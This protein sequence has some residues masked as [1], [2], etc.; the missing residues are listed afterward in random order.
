MRARSATPI[1]L[2]LTK[3][4]VWEEGRIPCAFDGYWPWTYQTAMNEKVAFI[5][6]AVCT[7]LTT[8]LPLEVWLS[9]MAIGFAQ[10]EHRDEVQRRSVEHAQSPR[11]ILIDVYR[12]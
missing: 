6:D 7:N 5:D 11:S 1:L 9:G 4:I 8:G 12:I 2:T 3:T 10:L